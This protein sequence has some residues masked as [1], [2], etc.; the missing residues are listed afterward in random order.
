MAGASNP[1]EPQT[2]P[3]AHWSAPGQTSTSVSCGLFGWKWRARWR[4]CRGLDGLRPTR[5]EPRKRWPPVPGWDP[6]PKTMSRPPHDWMANMT[7]RSPP[8]LC[9]MT[10]ASSPEAMPTSTAHS[11]RPLSERIHDQPARTASLAASFSSLAPACSP[12]ARRRPALHLTPP[13]LEARFKWASCSCTGNAAVSTSNSR[14]RLRMNFLP[15]G[16]PN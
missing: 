10:T 7:L 8:T 5:V 2:P 15:L 11:N 16:P 13:R 1:P 3:T 6:T 4:G 12:R 14:K 9:F